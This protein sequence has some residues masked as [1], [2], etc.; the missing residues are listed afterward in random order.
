M[1]KEE[2]MSDKEWAELQE[3]RAA[4]QKAYKADPEGTMQDLKDAIQLPRKSGDLKD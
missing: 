3:R 2:R 1:T 4:L